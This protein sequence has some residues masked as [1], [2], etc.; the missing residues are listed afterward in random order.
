MMM[1]PPGL[2]GPSQLPGSPIGGP[3]GPGATQ[4]L[5]PGA[6]A[7]MHAAHIEKIKQAMRIIQMAALN[8]D[9]G[10]REFNAA[11]GALTKLNP[12]FGKPSDTDLGPSARAQLAQPPPGPLAGMA[13]TAMAGG[14][15]PG[16][17]TAPPGMG[18]S[19]VGG[20][21]PAFP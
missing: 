21:N 6:G 18:P 15:P 13:P 8:L 19:E 12:I 20:G 4:M 9:P 5:S 3:G 1:R 17:A 7:G 10:T 16:G 14:A 2:G 11:M